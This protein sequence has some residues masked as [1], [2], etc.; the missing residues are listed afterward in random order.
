MLNLRD[1]GLDGIEGLG[2]ADMTWKLVTLNSCHGKEGK[3]VV[4]VAIILFS[5][6]RYTR[7][8]A[9]SSSYPPCHSPLNHFQL[10]Y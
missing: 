9:V 10:M 6:S 8:V 2:Q 4:L 1:L 7:C 5:S 3:G